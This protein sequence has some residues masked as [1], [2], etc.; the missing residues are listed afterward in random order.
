MSVEH[1]SG[2][3]EGREFQAPSPDEVEVSLRSGEDDVEVTLKPKSDTERSK[4]E[5]DAEHEQL[6]GR[7]SEILERVNQGG[8]DP[9]ERADL[10][11]E[12]LQLDRRRREIDERTW[13]Q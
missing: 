12:S 2:E 9:Q 3:N 11:N 13:G 8:L 1:G 4:E 7:M 6:S 10:E 5:L